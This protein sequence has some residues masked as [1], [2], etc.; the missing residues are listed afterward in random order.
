MST[1]FNY[2]QALRALFILPKICLGLTVF[3]N[4]SSVTICIPA[5]ICGDETAFSR[6]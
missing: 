4:I 6:E 3:N 5:D 1:F 2:L